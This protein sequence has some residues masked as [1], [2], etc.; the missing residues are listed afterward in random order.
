MKTYTW[1]KLLLDDRA[2]ATEYDDPDLNKAA[3]NGLMKLP[4]GRTAKE[5]ITEYLRG[6]H[7]MYKRAV[8]DW[9]GEDKLQNLPVD[10]WLTVPATWSERAKLLTKAAALDASFGSKPNDRLLLIPEPEAAAHLALKSSMH[11]IEDLIDEKSGVMV[12]DMGGGT[13]DITTYEVKRKTPTL[14]L[15]EITI[16]K[17]G[18]CGGTFVDRNLYKLL[19]ARFGTAF[20]SFGPQHIG[21][22]SRFM[23]DFEL[24]KQD[25]T[26]SNPSRRPRRIALAMR[27]LVV[28]PDLEKYYDEGMGQIKL[29]NEDMNTV[30]DPVVDVILKLVADQVDQAKRLNEPRIQTI[31][32]VGGFDSSLYIKDR[33]GPWCAERDIRLTTPWHGAWSAV[34]CGAVLRGVEGSISDEKKCRRHY[35]YGAILNTDTETNTTFGMYVSEGGDLEDA[36]ELYSCSLDDAPEDIENDRIEHV[37]T[38][39]YSLESI[40][41]TKVKSTVDENGHKWYRLELVLN[42]RMGDEAGV[43]VYRI[44]YR[45][46]EVGKAELSFSYT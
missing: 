28:T 35:G 21:P 1:T 45:G 46:R 33:L 36:H 27:S 7:A 19:A 13:V 38:I 3:G 37:G 18:K 12:S 23:D 11:H 15:R 42:I 16:G 14:K 26:I 8:I 25:F 20:T 41:L 10:Y 43:L 40:D 6:I 22:G 34:V 24:A 9:I 44:F 17:G 4:K 2:L 32:L 5:V 39:K 30:F 29:Y 31:V